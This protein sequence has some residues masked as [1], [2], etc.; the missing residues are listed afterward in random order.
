MTLLVGLGSAL[1]PVGLGL[2]L[3]LVEL[4]SASH[5]VGLGSA[6]L[7]VALASVFDLVAS[8]SVQVWLRL[9][10]SARESR[11]LGSSRYGYSYRTCR[12]LIA[13]PE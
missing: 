11:H 8:A 3:L 7:L 5:P 10:K 6:F 1:P 12:S 13:K 2:A 4:G 9:P